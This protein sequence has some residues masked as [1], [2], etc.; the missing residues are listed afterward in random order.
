MMLFFIGSEAF[1][2]VALIISFLYYSR[3]DGSL[4]DTAQ[5]L[6]VKKTAVFTFF[7]LSS[8]LTVEVADRQLLKGN[9]KSMLIWLAITLVFGMV[10]LIGQGFE[11]LDLIKNHVTISK[12]IFGSA[13]FTLTG[14]HGLHVIIG[15]IILSVMIRLIWSGKYLAVEYDAFNTSTVY[16][17]F[18]DG[19]WVVV[20]TVVYIGALL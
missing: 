11:Y 13:F 15:L 3:P 8:S 1:F 14:F 9:R 4:S 7:L 19:V 2:F 12:D 17:H 6:N 18:V 10:F 5:F 20:F 16:W